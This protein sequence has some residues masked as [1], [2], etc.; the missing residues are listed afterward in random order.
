M[1][2]KL[3]IG[4]KSLA[5]MQHLDDEVNVKVQAESGSQAVRTLIY[6]AGRCSSAMS[7]P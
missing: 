6:E 7:R 4:K 2:N 3:K 5:L 1:V